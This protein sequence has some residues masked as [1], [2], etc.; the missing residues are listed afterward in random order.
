M[1]IVNNKKKYLLLTIGILL[2]GLMTIVGSFAFWTWNSSTDKSVVFNTSKALEEYIIYD[3]GES[4]FVGDFQVA[5]SYTEGMHST[6]SVK[7]TEDAKD[8]SLYATIYMDINEIGE[9]MKVSPA[10]KWAITSGDSSNVGKLLNQGVFYGQS[11]GDTIELKPSFEVTTT[12]QEF[13]VWIWLDSGESIDSNLTG[14]TLDVNVFT[15]I[16]QIVEERFEITKKT[17]RYQ[18]INATAIN[19]TNDITHYAVITG[20]GTPSSWTSISSDE[21][22]RVY[23]LEYTASS[24][25]KYYIW[26]NYLFCINN[27]GWHICFHNC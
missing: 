8:H 9:Y 27:N 26:F 13:T 19:S 12:E 17:V 11:S 22:D 10:L 18:L 7:K 15:Q 21:V 16:D 6:I 2:I 4:K 20:T 3:S 25:G 23:N 24:T 14:E 5:D 1:E